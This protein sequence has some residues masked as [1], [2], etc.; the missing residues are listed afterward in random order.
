[1]FLRIRWFLV[2][3]LAS[4]GVVSYLVAQVKKARERLTPRN[5][6]NSGL[7]SVA[8]LLDSAAEAVQ[9]SSESQP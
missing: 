7:R 3:A 4:L 2:G 9:P 8:N 1:M 6:A 5:L